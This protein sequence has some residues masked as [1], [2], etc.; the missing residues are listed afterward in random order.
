LSSQPS[1]VLE[2]VITALGWIFARF[3]AWI[4]DCW[5]RKEGARARALTTI[6][7]PLQ[8]IGNRAWHRSST[9]CSSSPWPRAVSTSLP[10]RPIV[11]S[12]GTHASAR[13]LPSRAGKDH[14]T[15][16]LPIYAKAFTPLR[17]FFGRYFLWDAIVCLVHYEGIGYVIHGTRPCR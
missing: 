6:N 10:S 5:S 8:F 15:H 3:F 1:F 16:E 12:G 4:L 17:V 13:S 11:R 7:Y 9:R 14:T 2:L